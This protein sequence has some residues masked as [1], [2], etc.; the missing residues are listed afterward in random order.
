MYPN[1][2]AVP[3]SEMSVPT[4]IRIPSVASKEHGPKGAPEAE[5]A[6]QLEVLKSAR[7]QR[8]AS[9]W[10]ST[11]WCADYRYASNHHQNPFG[12]ARD[13]DV[14]AEIRLSRE[15]IG[16]KSRRQWG[17]QTFIQ[18]YNGAALL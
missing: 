1:R 5:S 10:R 16:W 14:V 15:S 12:D 13:L 18:Y 3:F 17:L 9:E 4:R 8:W 11:A 2:A 7:D 6:L